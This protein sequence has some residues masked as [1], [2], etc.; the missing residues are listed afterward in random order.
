MPNHHLDA[1]CMNNNSYSLCDWGVADPWLWGPEVGNSWRTDND[2]QPLWS[3][4]L[5]SIDNTAGLARFAG[6]GGW[7]DPDMLEIGNG[8]LAITM[9]RAHFALWALVKSPLLIG[10]DLRLIMP[11]SL[12]ILT[13]KEVIDINQ[14]PLGVAGDLIWKQG[15]REVWAAP[16]QGGDRAVVLFNRHTAGPPAEVSVDWQWLGYPQGT[17]ARIRDCF[18]EE[19]LGTYVDTFSARLD[20]A[21][22][23]MLRVTPLQPSAQYDSW[24][25]WH[26]EA[27]ILA[28]AQVRRASARKRAWKHAAATHDHAPAVVRDSP[29]AAIG[30]AKGVQPDMVGKQGS[31][32]ST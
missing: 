23:A 7:N 22:V 18:A 2:I 6:P 21:D 12:K 11:S 31:M 17:R 24:R 20:N 8:A 32:A 19:N 10:T 15:P 27:P 30:L 28:Q 1:A 16:L 25:P 4:I 29:H 26:G 13:S 3:D 14:D 9:Q 5:R